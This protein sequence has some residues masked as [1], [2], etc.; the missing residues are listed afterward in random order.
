MIFFSRGIYNK[1]NK[2]NRRN[3]G[4]W[5]S[6]K[7]I[8]WQKGINKRFIFYIHFDGDYEQFNQL[9][10]IGFLNLVGQG[11]VKPPPP[12]VRPPLQPYPSIVGVLVQ[13]HVS[14]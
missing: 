5:N 13:P 7:N 8:G 10:Q 14:M 1:G 6:G 9:L 4:N 11:T 12:P 2:D 3:G